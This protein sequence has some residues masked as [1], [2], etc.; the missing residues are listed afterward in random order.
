MGKADLKDTLK[1]YVLEQ[2]LP[3]EAPEALTDDVKLISDGIIDSLGSLKLVAF[4]EEKFGVQIEAHEID[5]DHLDSIDDIV[6]L[7][8]SRAA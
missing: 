4:I 6:G 1:K 2:F 7:I 3:G 5:A 8:S